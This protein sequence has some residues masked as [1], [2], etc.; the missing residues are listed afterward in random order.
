[1]SQLECIGKTRPNKVISQS[2]RIG[3][4]EAICTYKDVF[5]VLVLDGSDDSGGNHGL[6][7]SL[8][9]I[10]VEDTISGTIVDVRFHLRVAVL[11]SDVD[12][13]KRKKMSG[14]QQIDG[15]A[16]SEQ[17]LAVFSGQ[18][19]RE[20]ASVTYLSGDHADDVLILVIRVQK[21]HYV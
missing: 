11:G 8:G 14:N 15:G 1:M 19:H 3:A 6:L 18:N 2:Q 20:D 21:R 17:I 12:L 10:E 4:S 13:G 7:P 5:G 9:Q 16:Q